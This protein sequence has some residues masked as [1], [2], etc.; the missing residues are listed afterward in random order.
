M[1]KASKS[2]S[3]KVLVTMPE[4]LLK[5][6]DAKARNENRTRSAELCVQLAQSLG[7]PRARAQ[8]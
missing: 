3:K 6:L 1:T 7:K 4:P 2:T 8:A 5:R